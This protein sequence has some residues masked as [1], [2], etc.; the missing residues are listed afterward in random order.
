MKYGF[1]GLVFAFLLISSEIQAQIWA[2]YDARDS[3]YVRLFPQKWTIRPFL[4]ARTIKLELENPA[5]KGLRV[6]YTPNTTLQAGLFIAYKRTGIGGS[7]AIPGIDHQRR[8]YGKSDYFD[9]DLNFY[10]RRIVGEL[11]FFNYKGFYNDNIAQLDTSWRATMPYPQ[12]SDIRLVGGKLNLIYI[13]N[14][15]KY[16]LK[17]SFQQLEQQTRSAG[18][19]LAQWSVNYSVVRSDSGLIPPIMLE[20]MQ[21]KS[22]IASGKFTGISFAPGYGYAWKRKRWLVNPMLFVGLA[23]QGV[24]IK[25]SKDSEGPLQFKGIGEKINGRISIHYDTDRFFMGAFLTTDALIYSA[26][27]IKLNQNAVVTSLFS[28]YRF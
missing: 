27:A 3:T 18:S 7:I 24:R 25:E 12:R 19:F 16:S 13:F 10:S 15:T 11:G 2:T 9:L 20:Q 14:H 28:G 1:L 17:A 22:Q 26:G 5:Q 6:S 8:R 23:V 21:S 4:L